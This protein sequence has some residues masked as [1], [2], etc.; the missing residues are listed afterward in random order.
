[1]RLS[2][3]SDST[4]R[5]SPPASVRRHWRRSRYNG[6]ECFDS[7]VDC[8]G[9]GMAEPLR[10]GVI[11]L[12]PRWRR[13]YLPALMALRKL[14]RIEVLCDPAFERALAQAKQLDCRAASGPSQVVDSAAVEA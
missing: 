7:V 2:S 13:R 11:G 9:R 6:R 10:V 1:C 4:R 8:G 5:E 12:G 3:Y 14:F